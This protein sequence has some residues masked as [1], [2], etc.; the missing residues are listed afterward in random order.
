MS[1][2]TQTQTTDLEIVDEQGEFLFEEDELLEEVPREVYDEEDEE[3]YHYANLK[4]R[5]TD[6]DLKQIGN[7]VIEDFDDDVA[8]R[9]EWEQI[10]SDGLRNLGI[11][12]SDSEPIFE[13]ACQVDHPIILESVISY[14]SRMCTELLPSSGPVKT[15]V[16]GP[17]D[18]ESEQRANRVKTHMNWQVTE[19]MPEFIP[20]TEKMMFF[21]ALVGNGF[22][23]KVYD[24][25]EDRIV[26]SFVMPS[27]VAVNAMATSL[28]TAER[29]SVR[30]FYSERR[31]KGLVQKGFFEADDTEVGEPMTPE[32]SE[33]TNALRSAAGISNLKD[34]VYEVIEQQVY[35]PVVERGDGNLDLDE[36]DGQFDPYIVTVNKSTGAVLSIRKN[37]RSY[38][39]KRRR[40]HHIT[41]YGF[42]PA[43]NFYSFGFVHLLTNVQ[44]TLTNTL[45]SLMDAG[46]FANLQAGFK[47]KS[48]KINDNAEPLGPG[49]FRDVSHH[50]D[51]K[52]A[53]MLLPFREPSQTLFEVYVDTQNR[54][55]QFADSTQSVVAESSNYGPVGTTMALLEASAKFFGAV[56][57]RAFVSQ[58]N[59][60]KTLAAMNF[61]H[62]DDEFEFALPGYT[63][64]ILREDYDPMLVKVIPVSDPNKPSQAQR[65][66]MAQAKLD[67][68]LQARDIH[69]IKQAYKEFYRALD[70]ENADKLLLPDVQPE[71]MDPISDIRAA[72]ENKPIKAFDGQDHTAHVAVKMGWLNNPQQ[73]GSQSMAA[74]VP[75]IQANIREH[76]TLKWVAEMQAMQQQQGLDVGAASQRLAKLMELQQQLDQKGTPAQIVA[77]AEALRADTEAK[78]EDRK[79]KE[80]QV[81]LGIDIMH[82][83]GQIQKM[84]ND[85][86]ESGTKMDMER[87]RLGSDLIEKGI[88]E[89]MD[90]FNVKNS[91][92]E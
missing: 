85:A 33:L 26:D 3:S 71:P 44:E 42:V 25:V 14:Q 35:L 15:Q 29:I 53:L 65:I 39:E 17:S 87:V 7:D 37:W 40:A 22:K 10:T 18:E 58:G 45:R 78:A 66:A 20:E 4:K 43:G 84:L 9:S 48:L 12:N 82:K 75:I 90:V 64:D 63:A 60:L 31:M 52:E 76:Q 69:D 38:D 68:A 62:L 88:K 30:L 86:A 80:S 56:H 6:E 24:D 1:E 81:K 2:T 74:F 61:E 23:R 28:E 50:G 46:Q 72:L 59:E 51:L 89:A 70:V 57:K 41:H 11:S 47:K 73:G 8:S 91:A 5:F 27:D 16:L 83:A 77:E 54:A 21:T 67:Y 55:K 49:E 36:E 34:E 19:N 13:G 32:M 79:A 92:K